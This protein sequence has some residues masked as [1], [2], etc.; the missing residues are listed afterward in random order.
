LIAPA[1]TL[2]LVDDEERILTALHRTLRREGY[3]L[4]TASTPQRAIRIL[5]DERIDLILTDHKMPGMSGL[6][7]L[8]HAARLR[9]LAARLLITGWAQGV[10]RDEIESLGIAAIVPKPW[11]DAELKG[12]LEE[13]LAPLRERQL[14]DGPLRAAGP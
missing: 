14:R 11:K 3:A 4:R 7:L 12:A 13:A 8:E 10:S 9:P 6:E 1:P 2:L 5:E